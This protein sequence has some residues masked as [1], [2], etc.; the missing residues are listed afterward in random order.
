MT[1]AI[2]YYFGAV[3]WLSNFL[4]F[5]LSEELIGAGICFYLTLASLLGAILAVP[6]L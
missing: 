1:I 6:A 2:V 4:M 5:L 3:I